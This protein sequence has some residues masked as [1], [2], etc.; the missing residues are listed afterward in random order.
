VPLELESCSEGLGELISKVENPLT[1]LDSL[2]LLMS[3]AVGKIST[4][5]WH[6]MLQSS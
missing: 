5:S 6:K 4:F 1:I 2:L 3:S